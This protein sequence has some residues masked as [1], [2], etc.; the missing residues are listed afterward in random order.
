MLNEAGYRVTVRDYAAQSY[1]ELDAREFGCLC[2]DGSDIVGVGCMSDTLPFI[3]HALEGFK[4]KHPEKTIILGG[5]GPTGVARE[6]LEAFRFIDVVVKG[7]GE[8]TMLELMDCIVGGERGDLVRVAGIC[9]RDGSEVY[10]TPARERIKNLDEL[11]LPRYESIPMEEYALVNLVF[12]RGCPYHCTFCDVAPLWGREHHRRS[13]ENVIEELAFLKER[14][15]KRHFEF[16][17]ETFV[18]KRAAVSDFCRALRAKG[19][20]VDWSCTGR[21]NL[22][23]EELLKEMSGAGCR[24]LFFGIESGSDRV[25]ANI[26]KDCTAREAVAAL[27]LTGRFMKPV[28]SFIWGFPFESV[29]DV[30]QTLLLMVYLSQVG[31]DTRLNRLAPFALAPLF[32]EYGDRLVR[33]QGKRSASP[34]EP[35]EASV[36]P[37]EARDLIAKHP[38]IFPE[39]FW[40]G[41]ERFDEKMQMVNLLDRH[42]HTPEWP[43]GN[44]ARPSDGA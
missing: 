11:P 28:A 30:A 38:R 6:L 44:E 42:W 3:V 25:L 23:D 26:R 29:E 14:F 27:Q 43:A 24:A 41:C 9:C 22:I 5:P 20:D 18:F 37:P 31:V 33:L 13:P 7:E 19:L 10:D 32:K 40:F 12:S 21:V 34:K 1:R 35:F 8:R 36:L 17:D 4:A 2:E 16:T 39:F 15:G